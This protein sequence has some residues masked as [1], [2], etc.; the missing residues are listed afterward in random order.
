MQIHVE[1]LG[2]IHQA[3]LELKPFTVFIGPNNTNK[4]WLAYVAG[5]LCSNQT[6]SDYAN[7]LVDEIDKGNL[8]EDSN[9]WIKFFIDVINQGKTQ[10][11][12]NFQF[13]EFSPYLRDMLD[14]LCVYFAKNVFPQ[15]LK[16]NEQAGLIENLRVSISISDEELNGMVEKYRQDDFYHSFVYTTSLDEYHSW[17]K[18]YQESIRNPTEAKVKRMIYRFS[19]N[20]K[21]LFVSI[22]HSIFVNIFHCFTRTVS[23]FILPAD[24]NGLSL[25]YKRLFNVRI[26]ESEEALTDLRNHMPFPHLAYLRFLNNLDELPIS[27]TKIEE[28]LSLNEIL[29]REI[30]G[31]NVAFHP[32][33]SIGN[34][35]YFTGEEGIKIPVR[36]ASSMI[37]SQLG[38]SLLIKHWLYNK[39]DKGMLI[40]DEPEMN[41]HPES[42]VKLTELLAMYVNQGNRLL[43]TTHSPYIIDHVNN[44]IAAGASTNDPE[45]IKEHF[46]LKRTES[47]LNPDDVAA[48]CFNTDGTVENIFNRETMLIDWDTFSEVGNQ[49][50]NIYNYL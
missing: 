20:L 15:Y 19:S 1:N 17:G 39:K 46:W 37:H 47:F 31:G 23:N 9:S 38:L 49:M 41:L 33:G 4:T 35:L 7:H 43:V 10:D 29:E 28:L 3:T 21:E 45:T 13:E 27:L 22:Y 16:L 40:F 34:D 48:Y 2:R 36:A 18:D 44:L 24:R 6:A 25:Y 8:T 14:D 30:M 42:I 12:M 50:S 26:T 5:G 32:K 11:V